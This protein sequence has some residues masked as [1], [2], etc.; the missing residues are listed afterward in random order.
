MKWWQRLLRREQL[1]RELDAELRDHF[2]RH[3]ADHRRNGLSETEAR[4]R[5]RADSD[6]LDQ[7]KEACRDARGTRWID[8]LTQDLRF[9]TRVLMKDRSFT[10][11]ALGTLALAIGVNTA[12]FSVIEAVL[13]E[14]LPFVEPGRLVWIAENDLRGPNKLATV[15]AQDVDAW[16][17]SARSLETISVLLTGDATVGREDPQ[18]VRVA[19]VSES[20][21]KLFGTPPMMG[22]DFLPQDFASAPQAPGL[23]A[24]AENR[25]DT[26]V[27][28]LSDRLIRRLGRDTSI[29]GETLTINNL[30]YAIIGVLRPDFRLP[31]APSLQLGVGPPADI[32]V[33]INTT[34]SRTYRGPGALLGRLTP[35]ADVVSAST[36]LDGIRAAANRS[37]PN[38]ESSS[39]LSLQVLALHDYMVSDTRAILLVV[40]ASVGFVLLVACV[41][42]VNL[43]LARAVAREPEAALRAAL[44]AGRWR[45]VRQMLTE[46]MLL[47][48]VGG[49]IGV[50]L[51][52]AIVRAVS[53]MSAIAVPRLDRVTI[54]LPVLLF[55]AAVCVTCGLI[56]SIIP[57]VQSH[58]GTG[59]RLKSSTTG[60]QRGVARGWQSALVVCE[61]AFVMVPLTGAGLMLR[62]LSAVWEQG[63]A[64][65]PRTVL[66]ARL[67][68]GAASGS[69]VPAE[70]LRDNDRLLGD[71]ESLPG[72]RS[73]ALW[74]VTFGYPARI[75]GLPKPQGDA[76]AM[77][78][79]VSPHFKEAAG[80]RLIAGRWLTEADRATAPVVV[81]SERFARTFGAD[82]TDMQSVVGRTTIGPFPA[83]GSSE[84]DGPLTIVGV[85][86]DFRSGRLGIL[87]PDD[88]KALPQ[89]FFPDALR[90]TSS[91]ELLVRTASS[92]L[93]LVDSLRNLVQSRSGARLMSVRTLDGQLAEAVAPR[94]FNTLLLTAF[95][96]IATALAVVGVFGVLRYSVAQRTQ[97]IGLHLALGAD[98]RTVVQMILK[99]SA[100]L[101]AAG[102]GLGLVGSVG[103]ARLM[104]SVLYGVTPLDAQAYG[105]A[106]A[107]IVTSALVAAYLP[108]HRASR[109]DPLVALRHE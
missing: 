84:R 28:V 17:G 79:N 54:S 92:P 10:L 25:S 77:W 42:I 99:R 37:R 78:F 53:R 29:V 61:L 60:T 106:T 67:Q 22:R 32:D 76:V 21:S 64:S 59:R 70:R 90:P 30:P 27:A 72:V 26:G 52:S 91:G 33:I 8:E 16:R 41:N 50:L 88:E 87:R 31:L 20:L 46:N 85:V 47:V 49:V 63:A 108:A 44:G 82:V 11:A 96:A 9:A 57:A 81:V 18:Q 58:R 94:S 40:W 95:A 5:A 68:G 7:I 105:V 6:G 13:F 48:L 23:R 19:A 102:V 109:L 66:M 24:S 34:L 86:S 89:V 3:V 36:E 15:V 71:I 14:P 93:S 4:Q 98:R 97:E 62:S 51:G 38:N 1:E 2:E 65:A 83:A 100:I 39:H 35:T 56:V 104:S 73:A 107:L 12:V 55:T 103:V 74:G 69:V 80:L 101:V 43:L 45:L 75:A